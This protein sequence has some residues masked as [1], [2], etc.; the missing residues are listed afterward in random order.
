MKTRLLIA[1][2]VIP[3]FGSSQATAQTLRL[4]Q[5]ASGFSQPLFAGA[6]VGDPRLF[7]VEKTGA[8]RLVIGG[9]VQP[10]PF[11]NI[12]GLINTAG[13]R[14]LLGLAFDPAY[15]ANGRFY[16]NYIDG[17]SLNTV[18]ARYTVSANPNI[19]N[20]SSAQTIISIPQ[21]PFSNHKAGW[22]D[23]RPGENNNL[24]IATGD[25]GSSNDPANR[26]QNLN[27]NLG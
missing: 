11:L 20:A 15:A 6:P 8:I 21:A 25:G 5:V 13:E 24:Y 18:V 14:G 12:S 16:V 4:Q 27:D 1:T 2:L 3:F 26:A 9:V 19:A 10:Q 7:I 17:T 22:I 23:F